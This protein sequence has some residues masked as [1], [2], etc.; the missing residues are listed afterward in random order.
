MKT[1]NQYLRQI[2]ENTSKGGSGSSGADLS[3]IE[4]RLTA[5][6]Q[7]NGSS[8]GA[9]AD[10]MVTPKADVIVS[11]SNVRRIPLAIMGD[12]DKMVGLT[13]KESFTVGISFTQSMEFCIYDEERN[14]CYYAFEAYCTYDHQ[15]SAFDCE[16][17]IL[18]VNND[19][20][21][22]GVHMTDE[23]LKAYDFSYDI[24]ISESPQE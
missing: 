3:E 8:S 21:M 9:V 1:D 5:L 20:I 7:N 22:N 12:D 15:N 17:Y 18:G 6:E 19:Q 14:M 4:A 16:L 2:A 11:F 10:I 23:E 24:E 13:N